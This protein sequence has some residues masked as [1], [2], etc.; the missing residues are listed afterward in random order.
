[1]AAIGEAA[2]CFEQ[3]VCVCAAGKSGI[4]TLLYYYFAT[5][6]G[7]SVYEQSVRLE[8]VS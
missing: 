7:Q 2:T 5:C 1:M 8:I 4:A 6:F 3:R